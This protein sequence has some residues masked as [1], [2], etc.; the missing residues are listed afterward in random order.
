LFLAHVVDAVVP[1]AQRTADFRAL[2]NR[3]ESTE[4]A[5]ELLDVCCRI[6]RAGSR[7]A[8]TIIPGPPPDIMGGLRTTAPP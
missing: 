8:Q 5:S 6:G 2:I 4:R 7:A 1:R 3:W